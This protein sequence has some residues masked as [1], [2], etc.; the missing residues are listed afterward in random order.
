MSRPAVVSTKFVVILTEEE[1]AT[2]TEQVSLGRTTLW[3]LMHARILLEA[4]AGPSGL[5]WT[6]E[7]IADA[8]DAGLGTIARIC[9]AFMDHERTRSPS[10]RSVTGGRLI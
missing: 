4:G 10:S 8:V 7:R 6:E 5:G 3:T 1:R 2:R 9:R